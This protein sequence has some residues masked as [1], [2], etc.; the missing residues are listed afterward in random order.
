MA[1]PDANSAAEPSVHAGGTSGSSLAGPPPP[2]ERPIPQKAKSQNI[3]VSPVVL[4][5]ARKDGQELLQFL[6]TSPEG[7]TQ[8]EAEERARATGPN[9]VAQERPQGWPVRLLK[10]LRNP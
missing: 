10:I 7:L 4:D 2:D 3:R 1:I 9:E 6:R 5:A 8:T